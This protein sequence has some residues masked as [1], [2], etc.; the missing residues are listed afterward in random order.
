V[1]SIAER[2][3]SSAEAWKPEPGDKLIGTVVEVDERTSDYG[4]YPLLIVETDA[5]DEVAC[6]AFHTVLKN[7]LARKRPVAGDTIGIVYRGRDADRGYEMYRVVIERATPQE[8][9]VDW[10]VHQQD[11]DAELGEQPA[12]KP[13]LRTAGPDEQVPPPSE[14]PP[15]DVPF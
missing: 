3:E 11:S 1:R 13:A 10:S 7:E 5:G 15:A 2:L 4:A 9:A 8:P 12:V 14:E 6:H